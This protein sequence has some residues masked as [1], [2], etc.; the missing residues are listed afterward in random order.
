M[1]FALSNNV[2]ASRF[3]CSC[4]RNCKQTRLVAAKTEMLPS[5]AEALH[6]E[7]PTII[8]IP[9][10]MCTSPACINAG[11]LKNPITIIIKINI[12]K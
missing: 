4:T 1:S 11:K 9:K 12:L 10:N 3:F 5:T 6:G 7:S 2:L 8:N